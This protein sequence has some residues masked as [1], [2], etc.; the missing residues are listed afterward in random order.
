[1]FISSQRLL[2][3]TVIVLLAAC[4]DRTSKRT[5]ADSRPFY[6]L[7]PGCTFDGKPASSDD[8]SQMQNAKVISDECYAPP[9]PKV[10]TSRTF[11][12]DN[13]GCTFDGKPG[14]GGDMRQMVNAKVISEACY[15]TPSPQQVGAH[16]ETSRVMNLSNPGCKIDGAPG[17]N[18]D[19]KTVMNAKLI[20]EECFSAP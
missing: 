4:S 14:S 17:A 12:P 20:S 10:T 19:V 8:L 18:A 11:Y 1:M 3:C 13:P 2:V 6:P 9:T 15:T 5:Q 7:N 16:T